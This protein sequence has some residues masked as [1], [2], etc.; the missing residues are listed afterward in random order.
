MQTATRKQRST[1]GAF[2]GFLSA[3][4]L[5][6]KFKNNGDKS[7]K[8]K[9]INL[10]DQS[11]VAPARQMGPPPTIVITHPTIRRPGRVGQE[12]GEAVSGLSEQPQTLDQASS[13]PRIAD[14]DKILPP[15]PPPSDVGHGVP[16]GKELP[17]PP[18]PSTS[19][20]NAPSASA[21]SPDGFSSYITPAYYAIMSDH[22]GQNALIPSSPN[23]TA[24]QAGTV[25]P[26]SS[27]QPPQPSTTG[28]PKHAEEDRGQQH[29]VDESQAQAEMPSSSLVTGSDIRAEQSHEDSKA[30]TPIA[31]GSCP[32]SSP[33]TISYSPYI[34]PSS[35][36]PDQNQTQTASPVSYVNQ[37]PAPVAG[38]T[39]S[40]HQVTGVR[41]TELRGNGNGGH[42]ETSI[43]MSA[44]TSSS[45]P[46]SNVGV[47]AADSFS[48]TSQ[49]QPHPNTS[50]Q[51]QPQSHYASSSSSRTQTMPTTSTS[52]PVPE[53]SR[54]VP[55]SSSTSTI[56][57][58]PPMRR[59]PMPPFLPPP[60]P[61]PLP[62]ITPTSH[63]SQGQ[64]GGAEEVVV[65]PQV[66]RLPMIPRAATE[67]VASLSQNTNSVPAPAARRLLPPTPRPKSSTTGPPA[68][69]PTTKRSLPVPPPFPGVNA[70]GG[71]AVYTA[72]LV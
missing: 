7:G 70:G 45:S 72:G 4:S 61:P 57:S 34:H 33:S 40:A 3:F 31:S 44:P 12:G 60:P 25:E 21:Y 30:V 28:S 56:P 27:S 38:T 58:P 5:G 52:A 64:P 50:A 18:D 8:K 26:S 14:A 65:R 43:S 11:Q 29:H 37:L 10:D 24:G 69:T 66:R 47:H 68:P 32:E 63:Q 17:A 54:S 67:P 59:L 19:Q 36:P 42:K 51:P 55:A 2:D 41:E 71:Q 62:L 16:N 39:S 48:S 6:R 15:I 49:P 23:Q 22:Q 46:G 20:H 35:S 1:G 13:P 53:A 9:V